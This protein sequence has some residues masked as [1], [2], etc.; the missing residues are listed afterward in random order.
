MEI[1]YKTD[2]VAKID[3][4]IFKAKTENNI[5]IGIKLSPSEYKSFLESKLFSYDKDCNIV[6]KGIVII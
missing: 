3:E 5:I 6:Y 4:A 1:I 2:I